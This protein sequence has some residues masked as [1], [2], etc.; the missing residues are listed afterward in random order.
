MVSA[1][2]GTRDEVT[3]DAV[4]PSTEDDEVVDENDDSEGVRDTG[5]ISAAS[6]A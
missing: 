1:V 6:A 4:V 2:D 5:E 3:D